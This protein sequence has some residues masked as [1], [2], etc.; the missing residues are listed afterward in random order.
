MA[1]EPLDYDPV[2]QISLI[3]IRGL[4]DDPDR[5]H[6]DLRLGYIN[7]KGYL[8]SNLSPQFGDRRLA[9]SYLRCN[10]IHLFADQRLTHVVFPTT[11][12]GMMHE[13]PTA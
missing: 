3:R 8:V 9:F 13:R 11:T 6:T 1:R 5:R 7:M 4:A 10:P 12:H 2:V